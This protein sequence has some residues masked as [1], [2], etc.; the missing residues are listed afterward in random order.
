M[1]TDAPLR[2]VDFVKK[3]GRGKTLSQDMSFEESR[4]AFTALLEGAF[5]PAQLGAF[6]QALRIKELTQDE[7]NALAEVFHGRTRL[8][9]RTLAGDRT[10]V[11]NLASDTGRKGGLAA[12]LAGR[13]LPR[14]GIGV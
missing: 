5:S 13:L 10:L 12:L 3:V 8:D 11:L 6:L 7:L 9:E 14:F 1:M 2:P 4:S